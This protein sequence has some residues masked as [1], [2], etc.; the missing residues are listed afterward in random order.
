YD[1]GD[2]EREVLF[3][4]IEDVSVELQEDLAQEYGRK[5]RQAKKT[6]NYKPLVIVLFTLLWGALVYGAY[7][8]IDGRLNQMQQQINQSIAEVRESNDLQIKE[9]DDKLSSVEKEM[10]DISWALEQ[11]G[12]EVS[13]SGSS[14]R[15]ELNKRIKELDTRLAELTKSLEILKESK[16]AIH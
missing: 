14:T 13:T 9:L 4:H 7:W 8:Y 6:R 10:Q 15:E 16:G 12:K 11:T 3:M 5:R 2:R 1:K